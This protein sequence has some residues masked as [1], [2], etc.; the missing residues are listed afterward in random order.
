MG[1][2]SSARLPLWV[3][4]QG[5]PGIGESPGAHPPAG[6]A[7]EGRMPSV[8]KGG[9]AEGGVM[10]AGHRGVAGGIPPPPRRRASPSPR[11]L[12]LKGG[13][14]GSTAGGVPVW[15]PSPLRGGVRE[16]G[17]PLNSS[18][19]L[20]FREVVR[21]GG[22]RGIKATRASLTAGSTP[23]NG[24]RINDTH[25]GCLEIPGVSRYQHGAA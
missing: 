8:Q 24:P 5:V 17:M 14:M 25:A 4:P 9:S 18:V 11:L 20:P 7:L 23:R 6:D 10:N 22:I 12:P 1:F 15:I 16:R 3:A 13:V 19:R 21:G 2:D